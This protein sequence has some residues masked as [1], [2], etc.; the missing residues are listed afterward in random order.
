[1]HKEKVLGMSHKRFFD[2]EHKMNIFFEIFSWMFIFEN[3]SNT[4]LFYPFYK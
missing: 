2:Q 4:N 3:T 1:M